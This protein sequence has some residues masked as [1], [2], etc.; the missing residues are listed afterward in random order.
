MNL[1]GLLLAG[2]LL[3]IPSLSFAA[4][5]C[6]H[7]PTVWTFKNLDTVPV[8]LTCVLEKSAGWKGDP[9]S[10]TTGKIAPLHSYEHKWGPEWY[11]DGMG[12]IPG[13]WACRSD[14]PAGSEPL[15]FA[16]D[17]GE[18]VMITWHKAKGAVA[19]R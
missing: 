9:V 16:T 3:L 1:K 7:T 5:R 10:I 17:W 15:K 19:K 18:N 2:S 13:S 4:G 8:A 14:D 11:S 12:L 6:C